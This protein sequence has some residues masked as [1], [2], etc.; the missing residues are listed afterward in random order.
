M[1]ICF[2]FLPQSWATI[3]PSVRPGRSL[4]FVWYT[5]LYTM[6][7]VFEQKQSW[8]VSSLPHSKHPSFRLWFH[9]TRLSIFW[10]MY[11]KKSKMWYLFR[12]IRGILLLYLSVKLHVCDYFSFPF[13]CEYLSKNCF[14]S[15]ITGYTP[16]RFLVKFSK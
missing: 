2:W 9:R 10:N 14:H 16:G 15:L 4:W 3:P 7:S 6:G 8:M 11:W 12:Y 13:P 1:D 5:E